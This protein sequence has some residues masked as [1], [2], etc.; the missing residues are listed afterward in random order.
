MNTLVWAH[1]GA[2]GYAPEN[3][4]EAFRLANEQGADGIE[5]DIHMTKD[6]HIVV[7][8]D[9]TIDRCS[10]GK[11]R[12]I[13]KTLDELRKYDFCNN[14]SGYKNI[15]IP[16]LEEVLEYVANTKLTVNIE[17]K[18]GIVLYEGIEQKAI[19]LVN[20]L[21]LTNR[22][23][24]SSFNHYS[25]M[26]VKQIDSRFPIGLLYQEAMVDPH[27]YAAH[28]K[29]EAIHPFYITLMVP[30][31]VEGCKAAGI[32]INAWTVDQNEHIAW[33]YRLGVNAI[34]T[35]YPDIAIEIGK[36]IYNI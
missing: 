29:A 31:T 14:V 15:R 22:V 16:T 34:I 5:L 26:Q 35:N 2:S 36:Q 24:F 13:D 7:A 12:I 28:V 30:N 21:G 3:S 9:E 32:D 10:D 1:R 4:M 23:I 33:M 6:G 17:I 18:S 27:V 20:S 19:D 11:G 8:H 25:L